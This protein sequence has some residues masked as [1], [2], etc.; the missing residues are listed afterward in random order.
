M[1]TGVETETQEGALFTT[2]EIH[3]SEDLRAL[4]EQPKGVGDG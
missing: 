4:A 1:D 3:N 2:V